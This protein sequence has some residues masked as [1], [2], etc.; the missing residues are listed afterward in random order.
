MSPRVADWTIARRLG[1]GFAIIAIVLIVLLAAVWRWNEQSARAQAE[2][3]QRVAPFGQAT[4]DLDRRVLGLAIGV[5]SYLLSPGPEA[6]QRFQAN[7]EAVA[8]GL[9]RVTALTT[10]AEDAAIAR[11]LAPQVR[12]YVGDASRL[13]SEVGMGASQIEGRERALTEVRGTVE[14]TLTR[15]AQRYDV[16]TTAAIAEMELARTRSA[17]GM[18]VAAALS[19]LMLC[20][21]AFATVRAISQPARDLVGAAAA[22]EQGDPLPALA[23]RDETLARHGGEPQSEMPRLALSFASAA[24]AIDRRESRLRADGAVAVAAGSS[25]VETDVATAALAVV[26]DHVRAQVGVM[27][28]V[29]EDGVH[30]MPVATHGVDARLTPVATGEGIPGRAARDRKTVTVRDLAADTVYLVKCGFAEASPRTIVATP[31]VAHGSVIGVL[32]AASLHDLDAEALAFIEGAARQIAAGLENV[33]SHARN[34]KLVA[35][36]AASN[37]R[38]QTQNEELQAQNEELQSQ[39]E[40]IQAQNEELQ[41]QG[42]EIHAQND[43]LKLQTEQLER[44]AAALAESDRRK[45]EFMGVLAHELRNPM[46]AISNALFA[47]SRAG[48]DVGMRE[49]AE[50]IVR[51]QTRVLGRLIDDLL[52]ITRIA[53]N[54]VR[55]QQEPLDLADV[56]R[57]VVTDSRELIEAAGMTVNM[58]LPDEK[59]VVIGDRVRLG[60]VLGNLLDNAGKFSERG[61]VTLTLR[62]R[63]GMPQAEILVR[64]NGIGIDPAILTKLFQP[65]SQAD[66]SLARRRSGLGLGLALVKSLAEMHGGEVS[67]RSDGLGQG[68]EFTIRLP[69]ASASIPSAPPEMSPLPGSKEPA[70]SV[71]KRPRRVLIIEDNPD[72]AASLRDALRLL[73]HAVHVAHD[74]PE[75]IAAAREFRPDVVLCDIGLPTMDGYQVAA[76]LRA[77]PHL[78]SMFL[79]AI[80][81]YAAP[82]DQERAARAGFDRH[83]GKP[84]DIERLDRLLQDMPAQV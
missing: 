28:S 35:D 25:L 60:Q 54:K 43:Q 18:V 81:G 67:V 26:C 82:D 47:L 72:A 44:H 22:L 80:T 21:V 56:V 62:R 53:S 83:F 16:R 74:A 32:L 61:T 30:L 79:I 39:T 37:L 46:G 59:L 66:T 51:R 70:S 4:Q 76:K 42:E 63:S 57:E 20:I 45:S 33:R 58:A 73:G 12:A 2:Y 48:V 6:L 49:R 84:P 24:K 34:V 75:G 77:D 10:D 38:V 17:R 5:R 36:L 8:S 19:L 15:L 40:E 31:L 13:V 27:Y 69:L 71:A 7:V 52:D 14:A 9:E 68:A 29:S 78:R 50:G 65:F 11:E 64:D 55:L 23:L 41:S 1:V 3:T